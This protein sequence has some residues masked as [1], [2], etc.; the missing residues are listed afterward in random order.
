M[1]APVTLNITSVLG[2]KSLALLIK[3]YQNDITSY[4][5]HNTLH[6]KYNH[7]RI[8]PRVTALLPIPFSIYYIAYNYHNKIVNIQ[9]TNVKN[10]L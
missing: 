2:T 1:V 9:F 3:V 5:L 8:F 10:R 7:K 6:K 4:I